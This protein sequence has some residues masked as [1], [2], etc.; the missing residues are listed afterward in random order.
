[1]KLFL[2]SVFTSPDAPDDEEEVIEEQFDCEVKLRERTWF[3]TY[4]EYSDG[5][6]CEVAL[7]YNGAR[8]T[9]ARRGAAKV[10]LGFGVGEK[11]RAIY[12][13]GGMQMDMLTYTTEL[14]GNLTDAG[15]EIRLAYD[16]NVGGVP[17]GARLHFRFAP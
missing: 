8:L 14:S 9:M 4:T 15:G 11:F 10:T 5:K 3:I 6:R 12:S 17:R 16:M 7:A 1:M 2:R 13:V